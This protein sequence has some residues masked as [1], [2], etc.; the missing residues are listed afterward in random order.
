MK[1][2][3]REAVDTILDTLDALDGVAVIGVQVSEWSDAGN[4]NDD[5]YETMA[6]GVTVELTL[7]GTADDDS[8]DNPYR[9]K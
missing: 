4:P 8:D 7:P 5:E 3:T 9:Y 2:E 6:T 1:D